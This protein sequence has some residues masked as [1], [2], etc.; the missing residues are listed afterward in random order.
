MTRLRGVDRSSVGAALQFRS[1]GVEQM[2]ELLGADA[3]DPGAE[4]AYRPRAEAGASGITL[5]ANEGRLIPVDQ[6]IKGSAN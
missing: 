1:K 6:Q 3:H 5:Q 2:A 4:L